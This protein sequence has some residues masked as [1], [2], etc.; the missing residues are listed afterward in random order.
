MSAQEST[1]APTEAQKLFN[2][3]DAAA[4]YRSAEHLTGKY[5]HDLC[6]QLGLQS[7]KSP[8]HFLD[9]AC[10]TGIV[11]IKALAILQD[12][13]PARP[14]P[15]DKFTF[16]DLSAEMLKAV[17]SRVVEEKWP[18][19]ENAKTVEVVEANMMDTK[20]P[21]DT[22]THLG[23]NFGPG[24]APGPD[25]VLSE[26]FRMLRPG[27]VA[28]WT[29]WQHVGWF[30][31]MHKA[32]E[33]IRA[34]AAQR[35]AD[36]KGSEEDEKLSKLPAIMKFED[37][38]GKFAGVDLGKL[39]AEGVAEADL[40]RWDQ[41]EWFRSRVEKA[42]FGDVRINVVVNDFSFSTDDAFNMI[43]PIAGVVST[44]WTDQQRKDLEGA[45]V[46][47]RLK[48]W[49]DRNQIGKDGMVHWDNW[50]AMVITA[51]KPE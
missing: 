50:R 39:R 29:Q 18:V 51:K 2:D 12:S 42:G 20:L 22:Y 35:C 34:S 48:E 10:G 27:G 11:T 5:A 32:Y 31:P 15:E 46:Q 9:L 41:E 17:K 26:S 4:R 36:G 6:L 33:E 44:T 37:F 43:K 28:G 49:I 30:P 7:Y 1:Q 25:N 45:D 16:A 23:C 8:I 19:S 40:P 24:L 21:S 38:M 47:G 3:P 13:Q 14:L